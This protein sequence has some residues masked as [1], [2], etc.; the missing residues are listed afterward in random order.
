MTRRL[1]PE[2]I[3]GLVEG[4]ASVAGQV[5]LSGLLRS[6]VEIAMELT[7]ARYGALGVLGEQGNLVHFIPVGMDDDTIAAIPHFPKGLGVLGTITRAERT[8]RVDD[9][10]SH[11][12][13]VGFPE[14]HPPMRTFLGVPVRVGDRVYGNLYLA[15]KEGG[16]TEEDGT[17]VEFLPA[18]APGRSRARCRSPRRP[19]GRRR[20]PPAR[21]CPGPRSVAGRC[22]G[23]P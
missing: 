8:I 6:T 12:D 19:G 23:P 3:A 4:A 16:L 13:A 1:T 15:E 17:L 7:G 9:V 14:G 21:R 20:R 2:R 10:A 11:P 5:E 18:P 22:S